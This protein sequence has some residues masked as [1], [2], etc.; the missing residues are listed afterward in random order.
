MRE[1]LREHSP[2]WLRR[3]ALPVGAV[4]PDVR[5]RPRASDGLLP[6]FRTSADESRYGEF[7]DAKTIVS[8]NTRRIARESA[9]ARPGDLLYFRQSDQPQ[10]D[11]VM[12]FVGRS[13]FE[14]DGHDWLV[15]HTGPDGQDPGEVRKVRLKDLTRHP[16]P[17]WRPLTSN[18]SFVGVFRWMFL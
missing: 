1:A 2:E 12:V 10:P 15:Y 13:A 11:H 9:A 7:A 8:L 4:Y 3:A 6:L 16:S 17:R 14:A 18:P 5:G